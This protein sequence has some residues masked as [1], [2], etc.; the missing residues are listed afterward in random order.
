MTEDS[1]DSPD[2]EK[3]LNAKWESLAIVPVG[4]ASYPDDYFLFTAVCHP[5]ELHI[6]P[7][8]L[9]VL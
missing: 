7:V 1:T 9:L 5:I 4:D 8:D 3:L 6:F 2:D